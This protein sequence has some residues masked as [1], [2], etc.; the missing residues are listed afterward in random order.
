MSHGTACVQNRSCAYPKNT[1]LDQVESGNLTERKFES[2][3]FCFVLMYVIVV[4]A[5]D[6][7]QT[8]GSASCMTV[9]EEHGDHGDDLYISC[10]M[11]CIE[12]GTVG[13]GTV[14]PPQAAC[15]K[16]RESC[17]FCAVM[18]QKVS[19]RKREVKWR[20]VELKSQFLS[21]FLGD[22]FFF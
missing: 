10:T 13:G 9:M 2:N 15:L 19:Q 8:V 1:N 3:Y 22:L 11:P 14:L 16:V 5:Q 4:V 18:V 6:P 17:L 20:L 12:V 21:I 7:A